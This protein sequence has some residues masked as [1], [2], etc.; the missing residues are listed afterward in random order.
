MSEDA[1]RPLRIYLVAGE[2]SGDQLGAELMRALR[3]ASPDR[4]F[5]FFGLGGAR[6]QREGLTSLFAME[7][8]SVMGLVPVIAKL[9]GIVARAYRVIADV[10]ARDPDAL[11]IIDSPDFTQP[12]AK[13]VHKRAPHIPIINYVSPS[14]WAWRPGRARKMR[15]YIDHVLALKPFEPAA[16]E[17]LGGPPCTYVG[18]PLVE[19]REAL[20]PAEGERR[21]LGEG[22]LELL[23]LPGSRRSELRRLAEPF[24]GALAHFREEWPGEINLTLPAIAHLAPEIAQMTRDWP[25][26]PQIVQ[27][28]EAKYAAFRRGQVALAASGTVTLEL[29]LSGVPMVVA[30]KVS[31]LEEQLKHLIK[32]DS[33]VLAN[34]ILGENVIPEFIQA[35]CAPGPLAEALRAI[36]TPGPARDA[37][38]TGF[39]RLD[40]A[41]DI[42]DEAPSDRAAR[43]VCESMATRA[44]QLSG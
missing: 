32:V 28:E 42:G 33:I 44:R 14:V 43:L 36:V 4:E 16:H 29:A 37:Q 22:P 26:V 35:D 39:A 18:H 5:A 12:I 17:R 41:M 3:R 24:A 15:G 40:E 21:P 7:E 10:V 2:E 27:G 9:P 38:L 30:Y 23:V 13:R 19:R 11:V 31:R 25:I 34:L 6:M 8:I 1:T 20:Q